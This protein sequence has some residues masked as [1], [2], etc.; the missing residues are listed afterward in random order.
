MENF[1]LLN[2]MNDMQVFLIVHHSPLV[3]QLARI[4]CNGNIAVSTDEHSVHVQVRCH[5][6]YS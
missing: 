2:L 1:Q 4:I 5:I 3:R 6:S